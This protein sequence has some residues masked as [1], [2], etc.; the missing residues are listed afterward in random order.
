[1]NPISLIT[2]AA[3]QMLSWSIL[4][5]SIALSAFFAVQ[6]ISSLFKR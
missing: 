3:N 1:M 6:L 4:A 5:I 2:D